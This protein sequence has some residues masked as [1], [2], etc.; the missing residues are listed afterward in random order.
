MTE[1]DKVAFEDALI[2]DMRANDGAVTSG[3]MAGA[4]ILVLTTTGAKSGEARRAILM[5]QRDGHDYVVAGS[6]GGAPTVPAWVHNLRANPFVQVEAG[7]QTF[8]AR[9]YD[10][11]REDCAELWGRLVQILPQFAEYPEKAGRVIPMIR[12]TP[13]DAG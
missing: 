5:Y 6:K 11:D 4:P 1:F 12:L 9:A 7:G 3:P 2:A 13:V 10:T 8:S